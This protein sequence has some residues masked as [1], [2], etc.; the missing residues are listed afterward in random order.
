MSVRVAPRLR[1]S[2]LFVTSILALSPILGVAHAEIARPAAALAE[3]DAAIATADDEKTAVSQVTIESE[4]TK[5]SQS[6]T[7]LDLTLRETPQSV[8]VIGRE[9]ME[10]FALHDINAVLSQVVGVNVE[11]TETDR[12]MYNSRGFDITTFQV[13]GVGL[14]L[15]SGLQYGALDTAL[16]DRVEVL[17]GATGMLTGTGNPSA[18]VNYV[19]KRP[20]KDFQAEASVSYGS[21]D[22]KRLEADVSGPLNASGSVTGRFVYANEDTDSYLDYYKVNRNV[23]YGVLSWDITAN[24][25]ATAGYSRQDNL[26]TGVLWGALPMD[27]ANGVQINYPRST[28]TSAP[29]TYWDTQDE[30]TFADLSYALDNGWTAKGSFTHRTFDQNAKLLY[31]Y[32]NPDPA[33]GL[34]VYG[35]AGMYPSH[36]KQD[37]WEASVSGPVALF[38]R[39]HQLVFG[40]S[41]ATSQGH[42]YEN[43]SDDTIVYPAIGAWAGQPVAEPTYPGQYLAAYS[44]DRLTRVYA[45]AHLNFTDKLKGLVGFNTINQQST[46][47]SYGVDQARSARKFSPYAGLVY[48]LTRNV[49][50]YGSYTDIFNPQS[51]VDADRHVL[52]AAKGQAYEAGLKS[53]WFGGRLYATAAVFKS[54]Q[55]DLAT[56]VGYITGTFDT[57]YAPEDVTSK[58]Y[59]LEINGAITDQWRIGGG[60]TQLSLKDDSGAPAKTYLPRKTL[61]LT[62]TYNFPQL[63]NLT[64][65]GNLRWQDSVSAVDLGT[66]SQK[67]YAV[68]DLTGG[69]DV[70]DKIRATV[71]VLNLFDKKYLNSLMWGQAY[72]A[73][74]R[75]ASVRLAYKF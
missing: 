15:I 10:V 45:A 52:P 29:W 37:L 24:L 42:E 69:V 34:G 47:V 21:W 3:A 61:K 43:F 53:E 63:R 39:T 38:G 55:K 12:T 2:S 60:W 46:G 31:A 66:I 23:Y 57:Y 13:D 67:A 73:A 27:D 40:A 7:G 20:T 26:S 75:S 33:T 14:P 72:Y 48:D 71:N 4:R 58:G 56:A 1:R 62:T 11:R 64:V 68:V 44:K 51:E 65:G 41:T 49:S 54:E 28:S 18:T 16:F 35:M 19:R 6:A 22:D 36:Y 70:T 74:P 30:N 32:G 8:T 5:R 59:E 25:K 9:Q 17:R 50:L